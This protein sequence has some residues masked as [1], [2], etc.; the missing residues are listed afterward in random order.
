MKF[1][2]YLY[3]EMTGDRMW[4]LNTLYNSFSAVNAKSYLCCKKMRM[5]Y[6]EAG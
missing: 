1:L 5:R 2:Y 3:W 4:I 6:H